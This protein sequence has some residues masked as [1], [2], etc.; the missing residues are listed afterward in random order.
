MGETGSTGR[1]FYLVFPGLLCRA[2]A[3]CFTCTNYGGDSDYPTA[4]VVIAIVVVLALP[5]I[6]FTA[7]AAMIMEVDAVIDLLHKPLIGL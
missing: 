3:F 7:T 5:D 2:F 6:A 1:A 4:I